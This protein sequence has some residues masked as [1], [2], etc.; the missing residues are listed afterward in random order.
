VRAEGV[1]PQA[2]RELTQAECRIITR[3]AEK[4]I[5]AN[6]MKLRLPT[7][8]KFQLH[9]IARIDDT[10]HVRFADLKVHPEFDFLLTFDFVGQKIV[11]K[12]A[13]LRSR[14]SLEPTILT[15][16]CS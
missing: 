14:S 9:L 2:R 16:V 3:I 8:A 4:H 1:P 10:A 15:F 11:M 7:M 12:N 5:S 13:R 6:S